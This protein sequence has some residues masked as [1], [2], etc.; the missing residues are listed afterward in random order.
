MKNKSVLIATIVC[1]T[2]FSVAFGIQKPE[3]QKSYWQAFQ[4]WASRKAQTVYKK[5]SENA[6]SAQQVYENVP[7]A[8][9]TAIAIASASIAS[10]QVR[11]LVAIPHSL[12]GYMIVQGVKKAW[13]AILNGEI[14]SSFAAGSLL[15]AGLGMAVLP[16]ANQ[17]A[18][19]AGWGNYSTAAVLAIGLGTTSAGLISA[20]YH[21]VTA[22]IMSGEIARTEVV[23]ES[24]KNMTRDLVKA[25][26]SDDAAW[27]TRSAKINGLLKRTEFL[28]GDDTDKAVLE[29]CSDLIGSME[30]EFLKLS[31]ADRKKQM[32]EDNKIDQA[33]SSLKREMFESGIET[34]EKQ[35]EFLI[36]KI[37]EFKPQE[38]AVISLL[39]RLRNKLAID[40]AKQ[41]RGGSRTTQQ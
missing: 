21:N 2:Q 36:S 27:P 37:K 16:T 10:G 5:I 8:G 6:P 33:V 7:S 22:P 23:D 39:T 31:E 1:F 26:V 4:D 41:A 15:T 35:I 25:A 14:G 19:F 9:K 24:L 17:L 34:P 28:S 30:E 11:P 20:I 38:R 12:G 32:E 3:E 29:A 13:S 18:S 40:L